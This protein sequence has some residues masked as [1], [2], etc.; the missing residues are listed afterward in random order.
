MCCAVSAAQCI[1]LTINFAEIFVELC[2]WH[3]K[4]LV[5]SAIRPMQNKASSEQGKRVIITVLKVTVSALYGNINWNKQ[6]KQHLVNDKDLPKTVEA[7]LNSLSENESPL[8]EAHEWNMRILYLLLCDQIIHIW[9]NQT[10]VKGNCRAAGI[11][12]DRLPGGNDDQHYRSGPVYELLGGLLSSLLNNFS[13]KR[14]SI[15][16]S[17]HS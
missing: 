15:V 5:C 3:K 11:K 10:C 2:R 8:R 1:R 6:V 17:I 14:L 12:I 4:P 16:C 13:K 9:W 7:S